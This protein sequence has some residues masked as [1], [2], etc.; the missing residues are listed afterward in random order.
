[1]DCHGR[2][3]HYREMLPWRLRSYRNAHTLAPTILGTPKPFS[4]YNAE[5]HQGR[6]K[7][8]PWM[9]KQQTAEFLRA[10][11]LRTARTFHVLENPEDITQAH[12]PDRC[13]IKPVHGTNTTGV[14]V[15][16]RD[17]DA[18]YDLMQRKTVTLQQIRDVQRKSQAQYAAQ[19]SFRSSKVLV[20]EAILDEDGPDVVPLDYKAWA[21]NGLI[22]FIEQVDRNTRP[23]S[24]AWYVEDFQPVEVED[25]AFPELKQFQRGPHR[26]P[27]CRGDILRIAKAASLALKTA[28]IR[29][30]TYATPE[31]AAIGELTPA[32]GPLYHGNWRFQ[33]WFDE[34]L[35][36]QWA[37][38]I[39]ELQS[40]EGPATRR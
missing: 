11:G 2:P 8:T 31:G 35:G 9:N 38:A 39:R 19:F 27:R 6:D 26:L 21:F 3:W 1:M 14:M 20:E 15:L 25:V 22:A 4:A 23:K 40:M 28:Y 16:R 7:R 36:M 29:V 12:L 18:F 5:R 17:G 33:P 34:F 37:S 30:D 10:H 24:A 32:P 13:V